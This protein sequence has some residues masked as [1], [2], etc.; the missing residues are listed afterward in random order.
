MGKDG[1]LFTHDVEE[2]WTIIYNFLGYHMFKGL[3]AEKAAVA[4]AFAK[5]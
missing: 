4:R 2:A 5:K 1:S 3:K